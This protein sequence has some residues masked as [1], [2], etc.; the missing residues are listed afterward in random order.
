VNSIRPQLLSSVS[1]LKMS[2][3]RTAFIGPV[4]MLKIP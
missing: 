1:V 3:L 4:Q 2:T